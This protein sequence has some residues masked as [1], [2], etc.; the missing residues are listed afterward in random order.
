VF[1]IEF[2][3]NLF[4]INEFAKFNQVKYSTVLPFT[5]STVVPDVLVSG[6]LCYFLKSNK[7]FITGIRRTEILINILMAYA[8][9]RT[10]LTSAAAITETIL[11]AVLPDSFSFMAL[12]FCV[13]K[14]YANTLLATLNARKSLR[15]KGLEGSIEAASP[16]TSRAVVS[17]IAFVPGVSTNLGSQSN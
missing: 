13:G 4:S 5:I 7:Q 6:S 9:N 14:L 10:L 3:I 16:P 11:Y 12:D 8:I 17:A 15:R 1:G 2:V